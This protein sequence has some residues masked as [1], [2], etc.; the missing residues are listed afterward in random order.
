MA[1][2]TDE[3]PSLDGVIKQRFE[4]FQ[5]AELDSEG[6]LVVLT[7]NSEP[8]KVREREAHPLLLDQRILV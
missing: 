1:F 3:G 2:V 8:P 6:N 4:D 5:V 7:D